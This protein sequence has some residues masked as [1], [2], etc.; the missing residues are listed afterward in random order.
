MPNSDSRTTKRQV[1]D[2]VTRILLLVCCIGFGLLFFALM[3]GLVLPLRG[4]SAIAERI[5]IVKL[6]YSCIGMLIG[7]FQVLLGILL[8]LIGISV[9]YDLDASAGP[10]KVKLASASPGIL[11]IVCGNLFMAFALSRQFI[12]TEVSSESNAPSQGVAH[13]Q[14][15]KPLPTGGFK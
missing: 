1:T 2:K 9:D 11:L 6:V 12:A 10:A 8:S 15:P 4:E 7:V 5:S 13:D 3:F 14:Q